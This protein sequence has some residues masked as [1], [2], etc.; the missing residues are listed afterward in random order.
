MRVSQS[1]TLS[2]RIIIALSFGFSNYV[3]NLT[4]SY[5]RIFIANHNGYV[6]SNSAAFNL[7]IFGEIIVTI[8]MTALYLAG[9]FFAAKYIETIQRKL[10]FVCACF[11]GILACL[12]QTVGGVYVKTIDVSIILT[13]IMGYF[14]HYSLG[15]FIEKRKK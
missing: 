6:Y 5:V 15:R 7:E 8:F 13:P 11:A 14:F 3:A 1:T 4:R 10:L 12:I 2:K 9:S